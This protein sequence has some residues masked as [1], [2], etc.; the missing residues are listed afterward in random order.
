[1]Q[2]DYTSAMTLAVRRKPAREAAASARGQLGQFWDRSMGFI[3]RYCARH[4][5]LAL[6]KPLDERLLRDIGLTRADAPR[7]RADPR[8]DGGF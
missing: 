7:S 2:H 5:L 6:D 4:Q 8:I 1:M 3:A